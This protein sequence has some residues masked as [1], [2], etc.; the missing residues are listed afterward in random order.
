MRMRIYIALLFT[1]MASVSFAGF[2]LLD[3]AAKGSLTIVENTSPVLSLRYGDQLPTG[4]DPKYVR[5]CYIHP[6]WSLD[7]Q[8]LTDDFPKD[9]PH[10]HGVFW[11]WPV[12]KVRDQETQNWHPHQPPLRHH[13]VRWSEK[14]ADD[15]GATVT[16][17]NRWVLDEKE[18][19]AREEVRIQ[20]H[21]AQDSARAIDV[22]ITIEA[23]GGPLTLQ[24]THEGKKGY[25][26]FCWRASPEFSGATI[27]T[28]AGVSKKDFVNQMQWWVDLS[29]TNSGV[30]IFPG[31]MYPELPPNWMARNSYAG[32]VN[33]SW[34]GLQPVTLQA[35]EEITL[36]H[37]LYVHEGRADREA[38]EKVYR[39]Y[40]T[41]AGYP[42]KGY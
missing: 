1:S 18:E 22:T 25:G 20:V 9:H 42:A 2:Q 39:S 15:T 26:G 14:A 36:R 21:P 32:F 38:I 27:T 7:G 29:T 33:I 40:L 28:D 24:G 6:L 11:A 41:G 8:L 17:E 19:V 31:T 5:S 12:V 13:F 34:P 23:V 35:G 10:H 16:M 4:V 30:A 3:D 37:R